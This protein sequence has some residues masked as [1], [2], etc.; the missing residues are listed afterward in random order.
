MFEY[1][2]FKMDFVGREFFVEIGKICEM[3]SGS[4]IV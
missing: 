2:I 3:V 1:K 4:C